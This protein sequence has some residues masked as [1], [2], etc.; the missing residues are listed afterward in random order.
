VYIGTTYFLILSLIIHSVFVCGVPQRLFCFVA[1]SLQASGSISSEPP[2]SYFFLQNNFAGVLLNFVSAIVLFCSSDR[3]FVIF[4]LMSFT[5]SGNFSV[6]SAERTYIICVIICIK[7]LPTFF[8]YRQTPFKK[9]FALD[10]F[11]SDVFIGNA[12]FALI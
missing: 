1:Q 4:Q 12:S 9:A 10:E 8:P 5:A 7:F 11:G 3:A 2:F 6:T